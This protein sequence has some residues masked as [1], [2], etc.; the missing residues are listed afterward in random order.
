MQQLHV[1]GRRLRD[2]L[3]RHTSDGRYRPEIDGLRFFAIALV[4][5]GHLAER[6]LRSVGFDGLLHADEQSFLVA[7]GHMAWRGVLLFFT[8]SGFIISTQF[9][10][11]EESA[12]SPSFLKRYFSRRVLRIEPPYFIVL[13]A[14]FAFVSLTH[15]VPP[16]AVSFSGLPNS[17]TVSFF[18]SLAY[19]H[20]LLFGTFPRLFPPGWSLEME[21]QFYVLAPLAFCLFFSIRNRLARTVVGIAAFGLIIVLAAYVPSSD[22]A[23]FVQLSIVRNAPYFWLGILLADWQGAIRAALAKHPLVGSLAG[24]TG[25]LTIA[26]VDGGSSQPFEVMISSLCTLLS[27]FAM[28]MGALAM[29][30]S[31]SKFCSVPFVAITG[32]QCYSIYLTHLQP[33][34]V[35]TP[36]VVRLGH[37]A[38]P[39]RAFLT[40]S[41]IEIPVILA[42]STLF[43]VLIERPFMTDN[44]PTRLHDFLVRSM[45][46]PPV[47]MA[48]E[49]PA[50]GPADLT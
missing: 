16:D 25:A 5:F 8:I 4:V 11:R 27:V 18:A 29:E 48:G 38:S 35:I 45:T 6:C 1:L 34:Q 36:I 39:M 22:H 3:R 20:G 46:K 10:K 23:P 30:N 33:M 21:I 47:S 44:W 19:A 13:I 49:E 7:I 40:T 32:G 26:I 31:F 28:F 12:L 42:A 41:V 37:I 43:Y 15:Y 9:L 24:W 14:T 50:G 17:M 2:R